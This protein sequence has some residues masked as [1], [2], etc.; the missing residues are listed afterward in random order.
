MNKKFYIVKPKSEQR[1]Y[2]ADLGE[3][4]RQLE[5]ICKETTGMNR[6]QWANHCL[7]L[8]YFDDSDY[9]FYN[10]MLESGLRSGVVRDG[11]DVECNVFEVTLHD[12]PEYGD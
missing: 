1:L 9:T 5:V 12:R 11:K 6:Q 3:F 2:S 4:V 8:G 10:S 7:D